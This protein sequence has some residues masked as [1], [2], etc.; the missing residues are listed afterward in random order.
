MR[1]GAEDKLL[2]PLAG[3]LLLG[4]VIE[5]AA[6][7]PFGRRIAV[8]PHDDTARRAL[9]AAAGFDVID[10]PKPELGMG[11]SLSLAANM[12]RSEQAVVMLADMPLIPAAHIRALMAV[13]G[14][15]FTQAANTAQP[16]VCLSRRAIETLRHANGDEGLR[17]LRGDAA[18]LTLPDALARDVDTVED[19]TS[20]SDNWLTLS[21]MRD[22]YRP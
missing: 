19:L 1:F 3:Q 9:F 15:V 8:V 20:L 4:H 12:C 6:S 22:S 5:T 16:P 11:H 14:T 7:I 10:N 18:T 17:G 2:A 13:G 21:Q